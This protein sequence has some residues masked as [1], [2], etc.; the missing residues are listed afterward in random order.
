MRNKIAITTI[1]LF[2]LLIS[3]ASAD[4][5]MNVVINGQAVLFNDNPIIQNGVTLVQFKPVFDQLGIN[6]TWNQAKK[7]IIG[8]KGGS[9]IILNVG[10]KTAYINGSPLVLQ[11]APKVVNGSVF[12]PLRFVSEATG[13]YLNV[14][15]NRIEITSLSQTSS[16]P[17]A[18]APQ[19][20]IKA[21]VI[22]PTSTPI[23]SYDTSKKRDGYL[24]KK[25]S[26]LY[27]DGESYDVDYEG[28][29]NNDARYLLGIQSSD[30]DQMIGLLDAA[31][32][33]KSY[34]YNLTKSLANDIHTTFGDDEFTIFIQ[35]KYQTYAYP[36]VS[37]HDIVRASPTGDY[38]VVRTLFGIRYDF[39]NR[40]AITLFFDDGEPVFGEIK[41]L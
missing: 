23:T 3:S 27:L 12:V 33:D 10:S 31:S 37:P 41:D 18:A 4:S 35:M 13:A 28:V 7:Q 25:Y 19:V 16:P 26:T 40:I 5:K 39:T 30:F 38:E 6:I 1:L 24:A 15:G 29:L 11:V 36:D 8:T 14:S 9:T 21:P 34:V 22:T 2:S 20:T 32:Y 17:V